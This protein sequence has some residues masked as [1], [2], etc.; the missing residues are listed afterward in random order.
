M[1]A[2]LRRGERGKLAR[3]SDGAN[4]LYLKEL[5]SGAREAQRLWA[6][7][8][9][10][11]NRYPLVHKKT[12][13]GKGVTGL[14][15]TDRGSV[16]AGPYSNRFSILSFRGNALLERGD[17]D[18]FPVEESLTSF[19]RNGHRISHGLK[20]SVEKRGGRNSFTNLCSVSVRCFRIPYTSERGGEFPASHEK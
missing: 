14:R 9:W 7:S 16:S 3:P 19:F 15:K 18:G 13:E 10:K 8:R 4:L 12:T 2:A 5:G 6:S 1:S 17:G 11:S 20:L